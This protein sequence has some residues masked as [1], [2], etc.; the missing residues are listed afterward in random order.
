METAASLPS[1]P[2]HGKWSLPMNTQTGS[3][4]SPHVWTGTTQALRGET[5]FPALLMSGQ[6]P[7]GQISLSAACMAQRQLHSGT[8]SPCPAQ[9]GLGSQVPVHLAV[10]PLSSLTPSTTEAAM[11]AGRRLKQENTASQQKKFTHALY[12]CSNEKVLVY[13]QHN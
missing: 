3:S 2:F 5:M 13:H 10:S 12:K 1:S 8:A 9:P 6:C 7:G 4:H 11:G